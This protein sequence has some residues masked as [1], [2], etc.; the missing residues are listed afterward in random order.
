MH[1]PSSFVNT[2]LLDMPDRFR[3]SVSINT[4]DAPKPDR[5][6]E[7]DSSQVKQIATPQVPVCA[8]TCE[9]NETS[10]SN[11]TT[12]LAADKP[13]VARCHVSILLCM[14]CAIGVALGLCC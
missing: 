11:T 4:F 7:V 5:P 9:N 12:G 2:H 1:A 8:P 14:D 6:T 10:T 3:T 13:N